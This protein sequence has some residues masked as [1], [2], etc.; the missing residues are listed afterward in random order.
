[1]VWWCLN[2][3][4]LNDMIK[5]WFWLLSKIQKLCM[6]VIINLLRCFVHLHT[7]YC[8][9]TIFQPSA[10]QKCMWMWWYV[11]EVVCKTWNCTLQTSRWVSCQKWMINICWHC[12][13]A[14]SGSV[15]TQLSSRQKLC[16]SVLVVY[17]FMF[18]V[19]GMSRK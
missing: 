13:Y 16:N 19:R 4:H 6:K 2:M 9:R 17:I 12:P 15:S 11:F 8:S 7:C 14:V 5:I 10:Y 18:I 1:M 3:L